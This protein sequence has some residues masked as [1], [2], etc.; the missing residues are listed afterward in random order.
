MPIILFAFCAEV[1]AYNIFFSA[2]NKHFP[3]SME[4]GGQDLDG[5]AAILCLSK[6]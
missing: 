5:H 4:S 3:V 1:N 6:N 2:P